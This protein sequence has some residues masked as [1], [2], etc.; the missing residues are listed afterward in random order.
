M[1]SAAADSDLANEMMRARL[2]AGEMLAARGVY[3]L[4]WLDA[5]LTVRNRYGSIADFIEVGA[6]VTQS[7]PALVGLEADIKALTAAPDDVL[8][9]TDV[10]IITASGAARASTCSSTASVKAIT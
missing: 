6:P 1:P 3:G 5:A 9:L 8:R 10:A 7:V 2:R 4:V